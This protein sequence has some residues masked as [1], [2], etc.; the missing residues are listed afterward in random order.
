MCGKRYDLADLSPRQPVKTRSLA[1]AKRPFDCG[2]GHL[3]RNVTG[4]RHLV[5]IM[6]LSSTTVTTCKAI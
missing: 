5:D 4:R 6:G 3:W 2:V 1:V